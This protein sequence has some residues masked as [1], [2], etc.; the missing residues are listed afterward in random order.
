[1]MVNLHV[2]R[3]NETGHHGIT[4]HLSTMGWQSKGKSVLGYQRGEVQQCRKNPQSL[5]KYQGNKVHWA[6]HL[7]HHRLQSYTICL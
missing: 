4:G 1:M 6:R 7:G 3:E 5:L 2:Y